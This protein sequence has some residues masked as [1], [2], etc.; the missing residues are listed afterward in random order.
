[1]FFEDVDIATLWRAIE[2]AAEHAGIAVYVARV[3]TDPPTVI[4]V[5]PRA[6][7]IAGRDA[8]ELVGN[9]PWGGLRS[10]DQAMVREG[11][12][13]TGAA[14]PLS[15]EVVVERPDGTLIPVEVGA[16][17]IA[18][19]RGQLAF[20]YFRDVSS[21]RAALAAL[22][23][24]EARFRF[25]VEAAP[26]GVV[27]VQRGTIVFINPRAAHLL[28]EGTPETSL[29]KQLASLMPPEEARLAAERI[30][31]MFRTGKE[32]EPNE[33]TTIA[34]PPRTVEITSIQC[35]WEGG[36]AV[37][38]F[39][40]DVTERKAIQRRLIEAD[41]LTS[42]GT[43]AAGV[44][45][46]INNP[47]T[48]AQLSIQRIERALSELGLPATTLV[49]LHEHLDDIDHGIARVA[50]IA[51]TLR[52]FARPDDAPPGPVDLR[53]VID[54]ALRMVDNDLRHRAT[55]VRH[56][57]DVPSVTGNASRLEQVFVNLLL[58]AM[59]ALDGDGLQEIAL[60]VAQR[61]ERTVA[62]TVR[63]TGC[64]IAA[65]V[66][67]RVF[68]PF[69]TTRPIGKG[70]GL[71]L[72]VCKSIIEGF[73]GEI[74]IDSVE[75][76]GTTVTV[77]LRVE[78]RAAASEPAPVLAS[79]ERRR[80]LVI[81]D[82][83]MVRDVLARLLAAHHDVTTAESGQAALA[84][85]AGSTFDVIVC[86]VMMPGV[87]GCDVHRRVATAYPGTE[88]RIVFITGG[89]FAPELDR[90]VTSTGNRCLTKPFKLE[91][92]LAA[93]DAVAVAVT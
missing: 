45:H 51:Q 84:V 27:I 50:S 23:Q 74:S 57:A 60:T 90:Y 11:I 54:R 29:G 31:E 55:L 25:L 48:Y 36:P 87:S 24:S 49:R 22:K 53:A 37:L 43:L 38:A 7:Q 5:S 72:S 85:M 18:S 65:N 30:A 71:G 83:P 35:E 81:D 64:G 69:F 68:D 21:E 70:M 39:A 15:L 75:G 73:G 14:A 32:M 10:S 8:R 89:T 1:M 67:D 76:T 59:H 28:C 79:P 42:L 80:V 91:Q 82:E 40:R 4:Y 17:R 63:D 88:R 3:D 77:L 58:N 92:V 20:G 62:I 93:V 66:R 86:D 26:D 52:T 2:T 44:A 33:Y 41:R 9:V 6:A 12:A 16:T 78:H 34:D 61:D 46:E 13:R 47:L 56:F 19:A